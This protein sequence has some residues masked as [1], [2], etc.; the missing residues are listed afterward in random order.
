MH[1]CCRRDPS[2]ANLRLVVTDALGSE[3]DGEGRGFCL[4]YDSPAPSLRAFVKCK[5][6]PSGLHTFDVTSISY[7][8]CYTQHGLSADGLCRILVLY[9][10]ARFSL[11][12]ELNHP[13]SADNP[14]TLMLSGCIPSTAQSIKVFVLQP[15]LALEPSLSHAC[16][17]LLGANEC[18]G[19]RGG[20]NVALGF[21]RVRA[22]KHD[23][24]C[25]IGAVIPSGLDL[26]L[27]LCMASILIRISC[28]LGQRLGELK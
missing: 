25:R 5:K 18:L 27:A 17:L 22:P 24:V 26:S 21:V 14:A 3:G 23:E 11:D 15:L 13:Y 10:K 1:N 4:T 9:H 19:C 28:G 16:C 2:W 20:L 6:V 7:S 8:I 12:G